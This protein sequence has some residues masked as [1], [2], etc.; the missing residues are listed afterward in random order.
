MRLLYLYFL[1]NYYCYK[2]DGLLI[3][4]INKLLK[5]HAVCY[6]QMPPECDFGVLRKIMLP[7]FAV[8]IPRNELPMEQLLSINVNQNDTGT[9]LCNRFYTS[10]TKLKVEAYR[11]ESEAVFSLRIS[12]YCACFSKCF[13]KVV[14]RRDIPARWFQGWHRDVVCLWRQ[15]LTKEPGLSICSS[16]ENS[17]SATD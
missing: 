13:A 9:V 17:I 2:W 6:R 1:F 12:E 16:S 14:S 15:Q 5:A 7:P 8:T 11:I 10:M 4:S 3:F